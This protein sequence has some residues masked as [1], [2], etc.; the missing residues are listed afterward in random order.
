MSHNVVNRRYSTQV[1]C[2]QYCGLM[3]MEILQYDSRHS[4]VVSTD[5]RWRRGC[6]T[7]GSELT[8]DSEMEG[9][10]VSDLGK[11]PSPLTSHYIYSC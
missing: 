2:G 4:S 8:K 10:T 3:K 9:K 1:E 6:T 11:F 5:T 7:D